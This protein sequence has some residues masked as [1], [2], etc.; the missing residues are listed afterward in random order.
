M[1]MSLFFQDYSA[2]MYYFFVLVLYIIYILA[3]LGMYYV[4]PKY[5][6]YLS[7]GIRLF[8]SLVL[9]IRFSPFYNS[10]F[11]ESDRI[12]ISAGAFF[13]FINTGITEYI[14]SFFSD[15]KDISFNKVFQAKI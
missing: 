13:L 15:N 6:E 1:N 9:L 4:N 8:V 10:K 11:T 2:G 3:F 14:F 7:I 5:T 12:L